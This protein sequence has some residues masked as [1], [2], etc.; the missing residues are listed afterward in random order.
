[1]EIVDEGDI[2]EVG[3]QLG[4][5]VH[6]SANREGADHGPDEGKGKDGANVPEEVFLLHRISRVKYDWR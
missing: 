6:D 1:M 3:G 5:A 4:D 2:D